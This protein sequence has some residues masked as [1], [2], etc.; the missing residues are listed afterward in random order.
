METMWQF[1]TA[2]FRVVLEIEPEDMDPADSFAFEE[3]VDAV[4]NG[5]VE[6]F[7]AIV[8]VYVDDTRIAWDALGGCAYK[9]V[10]EFYTS[11]RDPDPM[12]RNCMAMRLANGGSVEAKYSIC[13]YFP[14]MVREACR[15]AREALCDMPDV[16][17]AS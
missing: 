6:W 8:A 9:T 11:H 17:C 10:R 16:R 2:R 12:N 1:E 5:Q 3:D 4:R 15:A 7:R 13:H 14:D